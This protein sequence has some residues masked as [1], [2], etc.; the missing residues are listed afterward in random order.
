MCVVVVGICMVFVD[1]VGCV[2]GEW[3]WGLVSVGVC[4]RERVWGSV[5]VC[6]RLCGCVCVWECVGV[7]E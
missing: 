7:S 4:A 5:C 6:V 2:M 3:L 1:G